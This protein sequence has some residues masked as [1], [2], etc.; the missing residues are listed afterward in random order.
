MDK[1]TYRRPMHKFVKLIDQENESS[2]RGEDVR[3]ASGN[4]P[5]PY[6]GLVE[7]TVR[8]QLQ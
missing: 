2:C 4:S 8:F 6:S 1:K 3:A 5:S 7:P